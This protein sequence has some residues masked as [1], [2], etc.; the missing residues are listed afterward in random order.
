MS[1]ED[2]DTPRKHEILGRSVYDLSRFLE[3]FVV[4]APAFQL[5]NLLVLPSDDLKVLEKYS[6]KNLQ[7]LNSLIDDCIREE[8]T[9]ILRFG[10]SAN[11][12][13]QLN[14]AVD[15]C[16]NNLSHLHRTLGDDITRFILLQTSL[17]VKLPNENM[18]QITGPP[19]RPL[20]HGGGNHPITASRKRPRP[21]KVGSS[22]T[23]YQKRLFYSNEFTKQIR[24]DLPTTPELLWNDLT[25]EFGSIAANEKQLVL[26][27]QILRNHA[28]YDYH[29]QLTRLCK[30]PTS[31]QKFTLAELSK[32]NT[33]I[34][35]IIQFCQETIQAVFPMHFWQG[36]SSKVSNQ[37]VF[38]KS[39]L[40]LFLK[41]RRNEKLS[42]VV[43]MRGIRVTKV[44]WLY[45]TLDSRRDH[46]KLTA[47]AT[48][49]LRWTIQRFLIPLLANIFCI[50]ETE[51]QAKRVM[52]YRKPIW[53]L[54]RA[55]S[56]QKLS[57]QYTE[58]PK[59]LA[60]EK[61][62]NQTFGVSRL[63]LL[64]KETGVRPIAALSKQEFLPVESDD[65]METEMGVYRIV[66]K[67][68]LQPPPKIKAPRLVS[69][70]TQ[71]SN[72]FA[73]LRFEY[74][75]SPESFGAGLIGLHDFYPRYRAFLGKRKNQ[76]LYFGSVDIKHCYDNIDQQKLL[77]IVEHI[78]TE[79]EYVVS[80]YSVVTPDRT[81]RSQDVAPPQEMDPFSS[82]VPSLSAE[83]SGCVFVDGVN[84]CAVS[85]QDIL[86]QLKEHLAS[87][88]VVTKGRYGDR[89]VIFGTI[90]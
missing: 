58:I 21:S 3:S 25:A 61:L 2:P 45:E 77:A 71:L 23:I 53:S 31:Y 52:Y 5:E 48:S 76:K 26:C 64:P 43:L 67:K 88:L 62:R 18:W 78:L 60:R 63:R 20:R 39:T 27:R 33:D 28:K 4:N 59:Q 57:A 86:N 70:N 73:V 85:K 41:L 6:I 89:Y 15:W 55:L 54:F 14:S 12:Q 56:M 69:T 66:K 74:E 24:L 17:F 40:P 16:R 80:K 83:H 42:N 38:L 51:F 8:H 44:R 50:T 13:R 22:S 84:S 65:E 49:V 37:A 34:N 82:K 81:K 10:F 36:T 47:L 9:S 1:Q 7:S 79:D 32:S 87:H 75:R 90:F 11:E 46:Q 19:T 72:T 68:R 35:R 29:R 30:L